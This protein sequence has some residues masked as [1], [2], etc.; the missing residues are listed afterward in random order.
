MK[1]TYTL[2]TLA[3]WQ[4]KEAS[5]AATVRRITG[6][7]P[8]KPKRVGRPPVYVNLAEVRTLLIRGASVRQVKEL[9][10]LTHATAQRAVR[11]VRDTMEAG[12]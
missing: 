3:L 6:L 7:P 8:I 11:S 9:M 1:R 5:R 4:R 2:C 10:G 12:K